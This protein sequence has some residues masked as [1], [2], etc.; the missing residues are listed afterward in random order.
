MASFTV[1]QADGLRKLLDKQVKSNVISFFSVVSD[2]LCDG[3]LLN[4]SSSLA[5]L[6]KKVLV[7]DASILS[8]PILKSVRADRLPS[9][10]EVTETNGNIYNA[11][12]MVPQGFAFSYLHKTVQ[13]NV[14]KNKLDAAFD[15]MSYQADMTLIRGELNVDDTCPLRAMESGDIILQISPSRAAIQDAYMMLKRLRTKLIGDSFGILISDSTENEANNMFKNL[16]LT[17]RRYLAL[18]IFYVGY[19]QKDEHILRS[20][21][22]GLSLVNDFPRALSTQAFMRVAKKLATDYVSPH[23]SV[24]SARAG[25]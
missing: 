17:A 14:N 24:V 1:D 19:I 12:T 25:A 13:K 3:T 22:P 7:L 2:E 8:G 11:V 21:Q 5:K 18:D 4:L 10:S 9:I 16:Q 6:G 20:M 15:K 23:A